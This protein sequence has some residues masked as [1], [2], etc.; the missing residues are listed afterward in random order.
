MTSRDEPLEVLAFEPYDGGSH[1][2]VRES[3]SRH[4]RHAWRWVT[5]PGR[6]WKWR[7]RTG[8][9]ELVAEARGEGRLDGRPA[10]VVFATSLLA[11][12]DLRAALPRGWRDAPLAVY[13]HENQAAYPAGHATDESAERDV[14]FALTNLA[15]VLTADLVLWNSRWNRDSFLA[16]IADLLRHAPDGRLG[17]VGPAIE[18][19]SVVAWP[20]VEPAGPVEPRAPGGGGAAGAGGP[21]PVRVAWPHRWEHDKGPEELLEIADR[22]S[23]AL[24]LRWTILGHRFRGVPPALAELERRFADRIDHFGFEPDESRYRARL[25]R[26]D[27]VLSTAR[28]EF[29]GIAVV[30]AL[31]AGCLPWLP[32]R[33]SYP[34]ILPAC[35]HGLSPLAPPRDADAASAVRAAIAAHLAPALAPAAVRRI[36][37]ALER[38]GIL[39]PGA[40][41]P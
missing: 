32:D 40:R 33:L 13:M 21:G 29:F 41:G 1:R 34:E 27:W 8:A 25:A 20:P 6:A 24:D 16:G 12:S 37:E 39:D 14:H 23:E 10:D 15:S 28:H 36:D 18:A 2:A 11:A 38:L 22:H 30:E 4:S 9:L 5:R 35:A 31:L 26:C 17:D 19:R 7:M 3:I